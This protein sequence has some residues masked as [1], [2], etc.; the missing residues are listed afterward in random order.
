MW[1]RCRCSWIWASKS[2][3]TVPSFERL[4]P[5]CRFA[6]SSTWR[7]GTSSSAVQRHWGDGNPSSSPAPC[8]VC[9]VSSEKKEKTWQAHSK[10]KYI[11]YELGSSGWSGSKRICNCLV[12]LVVI[13]QGCTLW[14]WNS[15]LEWFMS[16]KRNTTDA[17]AEM[18][19]FHVKLEKMWVITGW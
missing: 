14:A 15:L 4:I 5:N 3:H 12:C 16:E 9:H 11:Y 7:T 19:P 17:E 10:R 6:S 13:S 18:G 1:L 8:Y 2:F